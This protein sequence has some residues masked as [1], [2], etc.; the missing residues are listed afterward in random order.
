MKLIVDK[1]PETAKECLFAAMGTGKPRCR[2]D[3]KLC[4]LLRG[5]ECPHMMEIPSPKSVTLTQA[6]EIMG[7]TKSTLESKKL[8][9][10]NAQMSVI[11][12]LAPEPK[13]RTTKRSTA[14]K[15]D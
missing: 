8:D 11:D 14:K 1:M 2:H 15:A 5:E 4:P 12:E 7:L 6:C 3:S 13:K 10:Y 9:G